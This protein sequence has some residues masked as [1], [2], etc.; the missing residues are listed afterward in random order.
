MLKSIS[1]SLDGGFQRMHHLIVLVRR[2]KMV[3]NTFEGAV[4][5]HPRPPPFQPRA[6]SG[7]RSDIMVT[8][9]VDSW[10]MLFPNNLS[11]SCAL[12]LCSFLRTE[13]R[14]KARNLT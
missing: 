4:S 9:Q 11:F 14:F 3:S 8:N 13:V 12:A 6:T 2:W 10:S 1:A 5:S 7:L